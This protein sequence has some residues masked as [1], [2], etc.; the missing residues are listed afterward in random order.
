MSNT[1]IGRMMKELLEM[2]N[3]LKKDQESNYLIYNHIFYII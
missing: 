2:K 1:D 3:V